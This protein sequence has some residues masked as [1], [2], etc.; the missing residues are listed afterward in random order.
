MK[1]LRLVAVSL[2]LIVL[3][4]CAV[5]NNYDYT[6]ASIG[7]PLVGSGDVG[8]AVVDK[9]SYV[10]DGDKE[11]NFIGLQRGGFGNPFDVRTMSGNSLTDDLQVALR[12]ALED[13]GYNVTSLSVSAPDYASIS[14]AIADG[15]VA[16]NVV[17]TVN[18]WK[19]DVHMEVT[20]FYDLV[21]R[22]I[23]N[24]GEIVATNEAEGQDILGGAGMPSHNA[25]TAATAFETKVGRLFNNPDIIAALKN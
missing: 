18:D 4:G 2:A 8:V 24:S 6:T 21:L 14:A 15:G 17:L 10:L 22:V 11:P 19:T 1:S 9:R 3:A 23:S 25:R 5:G 12:N 7:L 16:K 13:S 20:L